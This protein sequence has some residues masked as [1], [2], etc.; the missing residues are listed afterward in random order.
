MNRDYILATPIR[1]GDALCR[2]FCS[3]L[4]EVAY[5]DYHRGDAIDVVRISVE[6]TTDL[7]AE[8][9]I[10]SILDISRSTLNKIDETDAQLE[11]VLCD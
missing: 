10:A 9:D 2:H 7:H 4:K 8:K 11:I 3:N 5:A 6:S 1:S